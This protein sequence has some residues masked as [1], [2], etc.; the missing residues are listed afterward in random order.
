MIRVF[1][2]ET[3]KL[4]ERGENEAIKY[5]RENGYK[6]VERNVANKYGEID[7]IARKGGITYFFEVKAGKERSINPAENLHP[8]KIRKF[9]ISSQHYALVHNISEYRIQGIIVL[10]LENGRT[11]IEV[12]DLF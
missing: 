8:Q 5:L 2:S 11:T 1:T 12:I 10:F 7:I 4:G 6:I 3:Q 9:L